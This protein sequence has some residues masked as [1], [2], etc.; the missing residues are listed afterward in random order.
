MGIS[1]RGLEEKL[2]KISW[3]M[4]EYKRHKRIMP[5]LADH[6]EIVYPMLARFIEVDCGGVFLKR[7]LVMILMSYFKG[8]YE[9][10]KAELK[11]NRPTYG[12]WETAIGDVLKKIYGGWDRVHSNPNSDNRRTSGIYTSPN[13]VILFSSDKAL[14]KYIKEHTKKREEIVIDFL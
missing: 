8:N 11:T 2:G 9:G 4:V 5:K 6:R 12:F 14:E 10:L 13:S 3:D 7:N 1:T